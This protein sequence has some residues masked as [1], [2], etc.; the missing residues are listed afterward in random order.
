MVG[1]LYFNYHTKVSAVICAGR[2]EEI[3]TK[4]NSHATENINISKIQQGDNEN[5]VWM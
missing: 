5:Q 1:S 2:R 4:G 3:C